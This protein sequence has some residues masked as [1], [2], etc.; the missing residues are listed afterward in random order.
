[1]ETFEFHCINDFTYVGDGHYVIHDT[2]V[3]HNVFIKK[4]KTNSPHIYI[5]GQGAVDKS[6]PQPNFQRISWVDELDDNIIIATDP[7]LTGNQL[8]IGWFQCSREINY[9]YRF[10]ELVKYISSKM[11]LDISK[12]ILYGSSAGGFASLMLSPYFSNPV[13]VV[14]NP[15]TDWTLFYEPSV[16]KVLDTIYGGIGI[17]DYKKKYPLKFNA[18]DV[19]KAKMNVPSII[20]M[21]NLDDD[22]HLDRFYTPFTEWIRAQSSNLKLSK[23]D[24]ITYLYRNSN[25]GH[26][27]CSKEVTLKFLSLAK[28]ISK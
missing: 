12:P 25:E 6:K 21:Q 4:S 20:Y 23:N 11:N 26:G 17:E 7:T 9:F 13:V 27:P 24:F 15:Q 2:H 18:I 16:K 10:S 8:N 22:F 14:N 19:F 28:G 5:F 1:M 3:I